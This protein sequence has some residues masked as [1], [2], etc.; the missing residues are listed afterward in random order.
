MPLPSTYHAQT[1]S[2]FP[3]S[4]LLRL[5]VLSEKA[6]IQRDF[7]G[8]EWYHQGNAKQ[9]L[10][11]L[12]ASWQLCHHCLLCPRFCP[13]GTVVYVDIPAQAEGWS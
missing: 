2:I 6:H 5:P 3:R 7:V 10:Q 8:C 13:G 4:A 9:R 1:P 12:C 11:S